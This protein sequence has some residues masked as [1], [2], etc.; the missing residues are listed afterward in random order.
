MAD[1]HPGNT[2]RVF[3]ALW[4]GARERA[5]L[6][7]WQAPLRHLCGGR[8]VP[9]H[10]LHLTLVFLGNVAA[11]RLE[12][13]E[14]AAGGVRGGRFVLIL[15]QARCWKHNRIVHAAPSATPPELEQLV[16]TL[17]QALAAHG[18]QFDRRPEYKPHATLLRHARCPDADLPAL[19]PLSWQAAGFALVESDSAGGGVSYR[20]RAEFPLG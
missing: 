18:F 17:E 13:L 2:A 1:G 6:A 12:T 9:A 11:E 19:P 16:R 4:P 7:A 15:D 14:Q 10:N 20:V 3:F 5:A 8:A